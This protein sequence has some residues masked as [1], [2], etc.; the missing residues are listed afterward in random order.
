MR[1]IKYRGKDIKTGEWLYG[2]LQATK[3]EDDQYNKKT[4]EC[5]RI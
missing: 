2:N 5:I 4:R 3:K 1:T